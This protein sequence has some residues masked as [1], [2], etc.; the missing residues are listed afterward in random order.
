MKKIKR[1]LVSSLL[2]GILILS[3]SVFCFADGSPK[4][5]AVRSTTDSVYF[6]MRG[7][8]ITKMDVQIGDSLCDVT[9]A[10]LN[11]RTLI[12][13]DNSI[14][15][16]ETLVLHGQVSKSVKESSV[17]NPVSIR[18]AEGVKLVEDGYPMP[19]DTSNQDIVFAGRIRKDEAINGLDLWCC[20]DQ[21]RKGAATNAVEILEYLRDHA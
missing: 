5:A 8:A 17:E 19:L 12:L 10:D 18:N 13:I 7:D 16:Y 20:G 1:G 2:S 3:L 15:T 21:I 9:K 4:V 6:Y 14:S 11:I